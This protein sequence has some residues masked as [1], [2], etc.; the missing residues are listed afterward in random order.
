MDVP[1]RIVFLV[2]SFLAWIL[3][4]VCVAHAQIPGI[5]LP[6]GF[7]VSEFAG[8]DLAHDIYTMTIDA[9]GRVFVAGRGYIRQVIDDD[10]DGRADRA[11]DVADHPKDG[12]MGLL[13]EGDIMFAVG[14]GALRRFQL[15]SDGQAHGKSQ[16]LVVLKTG[17]EH[18]AHAIR[19]G[20]DGWLYLIC[21]DA[22]ADF[23][24]KLPSLLPVK[25]PLGG[26]LMRFSPDFRLSALVADGF[27]NAYDFD[28]TAE[29]EL[30]TFDSDNERCAGLP[31]YEGCRLYHVF[32]G[33]HYGWQ[34]PQHGTTWRKPPY[35]IDVVPPILELGRGSPTGVACYRHRQFP[36]KYR[37]GV[38][39][40]DWTLG[41]VWFVSLTPNGGTYAGKAEL[42]LQS[43]GEI[44]LAPTALAVHP[45]NGDLYFSIG[46]RGTRGAVYRIS[47]PAGERTGYETPALPTECI[48]FVERRNLEK[49]WARRDRLPNI[50]RAEFMQCALSTD[51]T[52]KQAG[53]RLRADCRNVKPSDY[54]DARA[55]AAILFRRLEDGIHQP[56]QFFS[57][58]EH[59]GYT[60]DD[61]LIAL[62]GIQRF[63]GDTGSPAAQGTVFEG[64]TARDPTRL[65]KLDQQM[66]DFARNYLG[67]GNAVTDRES[68]RVLAMAG[69]ADPR[70][71]RDVA[72][73]LSRRLSPTDDIHYL[74]VLARLNGPRS[75]Y[76]TRQTAAALLDLDR[77]F[78]AA[79]IPRDRNWPL[80]IAELHA[81]LSR[82]DSNLNRVLVESADF[83]RAANAI[84]T[85]APGFDR[86][87]AAM[88]FLD[89]AQHQANFEWNAD[90]IALLDAVPS[91]VRQPWIDKLWDRGG[92]EE[93][94][95]PIV[96]LDPRQTDR[97]KFSEALRSPDRSVAETCLRALESLPPAENPDE[98][99]PLIRALRSLGQ[100]RADVK[101]ANRIVE[102][103]RCSTHQRIG[104]DRAAWSDWFAGAYPEHAAK[105]GGANGIDRATW[106]KRLS[107]VDWSQ[108]DSVR[109]KHVFE[110]ASCAACH[111]S[112]SAIGPDLVGVTR[113]L[114][115]DDLFAAILD[116]NKDISPQYRSVQ[117]EMKNGKVLSGLIVYD[118]PAGIMLQTGTGTTVRIAGEEVAARSPTDVSLMPAGLLDK[119]KNE[120][121]A[122]LWAYLK[123]LK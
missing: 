112:A 30:I 99:F 23:G 28:F 3:N 24:K 81:E 19:R 117:L 69:D 2:A 48:T 7:V 45:L 113:R 123:A 107:A 14:D 39:L 89:R 44:G 54:K 106:H 119:L 105:L 50:A 9:R 73:Y 21:G 20:P 47:Y 66:F 108:G 60:A 68:A 118:S 90:I 37:G 22:T 51:R 58:G 82:K 29:G 49:L 65:A 42:F 41:R 6:P 110:R 1:G 32:P 96:A 111:T 13:V 78:T 102:L 56:H 31:W 17:Q 93:S 75:E 115:R 114:S 104:L 121:I 122:D 27:R 15:G 94:L 10:G 87:K 35:F 8:D 97:S 91:E 4:P 98:L 76:V 120:E 86:R 92:F 103:L 80:R 18:T 100:S 109:G 64:Y 72:D 85:R 63:L 55:F 38:F 26:F 16:P 79:N 57:V 77:C 36:D 52:I 116:P 25:M 70:S 61:S 59:P 5:Q 40:A 88:K 83:A 71:V 67:D 95:L 84:F 74:I 12:A 33:G 43:S 46:G 101:F 62:R 34:A 11:I 53:Y